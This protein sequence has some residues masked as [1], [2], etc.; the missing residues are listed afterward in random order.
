MP[1]MRWRGEWRGVEAPLLAVRQE[2]TPL[3]C[4][5]QGVA[6]TQVEGAEPIV[7]NAQISIF[8]IQGGVCEGCAN[9]E[10]VMAPGVIL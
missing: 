4:G 7:R 6:E 3:P 8:V 9:G 10:A 2:E 1:L 5:R